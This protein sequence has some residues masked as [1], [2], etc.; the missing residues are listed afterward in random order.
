MTAPNQ[1]P[2]NRAHVR[3]DPHSVILCLGDTT[4]VA[5]INSQNEAVAKKVMACY[6]ATA[7]R[8][9]V[10]LDATGRMD[11]SRALDITPDVIFDHRLALDVRP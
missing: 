9:N 4:I 6:E 8:I 3:T 7:E 11:M 10:E 2:N 5:T 1:F